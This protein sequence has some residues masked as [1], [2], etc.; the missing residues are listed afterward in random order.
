M[1]LSATPTCA[2]HHM[3]HVIFFGHHTER[4][5]SQLE[6]MLDPGPCACNIREGLTAVCSNLQVQCNAERYAL[7]AMALW[8]L[9]EAVIPAEV[10]IR[11]HVLLEVQVQELKHQVQLLVAVDDILQP[12]RS[13]ARAPFHWCVCKQS[14]LSSMRGFARACRDS[15]CHVG[16]DILISNFYTS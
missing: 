10:R 9:H 1:G 4:L 13:V 7:N 15:S 2:V 3:L 12:A 16:V 6:R 11:V 5:L 8:H 14:C